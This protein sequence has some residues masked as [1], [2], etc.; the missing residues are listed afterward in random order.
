MAQSGNTMASQE[1]SILPEPLDPEAL[2]RRYRALRS[3]G[4]RA[5]FVRAIEARYRQEPH[6]L[7]L[8]A[9]HVRLA[10]DRRTAGEQAVAWRWALPLALLNGFLFWILTDDRLGV[11]LPGDRFA[12]MPLLFPYWMPVTAALLLLFLAGAGERRWR[13]AA[14][15]VAALAA[16]SLYVYL[17]YTRMSIRMVAQQYVNLAV[18]HLPLLA[19]AAIGFYTLAG[20]DAPRQRFALLQKMLETL[21]V[22]GMFVL[23]AGVF[24][25]ITGGLFSI[26]QVD[27]PDWLIRLALAG[28]VGL[29]PILA[30]ALVYDPTR[31]PADQT[32]AEGVSKTVRRLLR[33]MVPLSV[34]VLTVY[35]ALIPFY[36]REPL[37]NRN[38]LIVY[39]SMLFAVMVLMLG[40][41]PVDEEGEP[42]PWL[43]WGMMV[44]ALLAVLV[45]LYALY[46][47]LYRTWHG[48]LT[49]H[50]VAFIGWDVLNLALLCWLLLTL[51]RRCRETEWAGHVQK[52]FAR[53]AV[54]YPI[55][56]LV[57]LL[58]LPWWFGRGLDPTYSHLPPR[59]QEAIYGQGYPILLKC[60]GSPH[61]YLL[62]RGK[63]RWIKDIP[64]FEAQGFRWSDVREVP[65][66]D[67]RRIPDGPPIPPT[68]GTPPVPYGPYET[69]VPP[70]P[71]DSRLP[72]RLFLDASK[73]TLPIAAIPRW[74]P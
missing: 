6:N 67:L 55:W 25:S 18:I 45:G 24:M 39:T 5:A 51:W 40:I 21:F 46:A 10:W 58:A 4:E 60:Y 7:L 69:P 64:T 57:V 22:A 65:C 72:G 11:R 33:I 53:A 59:V 13:R 17:A 34:V 52:V 2:E 29:I 70:P 32:F 27:F 15:G 41:T 38:A 74:Y 47:I 54:V 12:Y 63:K 26:L 61:V 9:W 31:A 50:R 49:P 28:G 1:T 16:V 20:R 66:A 23:V 37:H 62:E 73:A 35:A 43:R 68:A 19:L 14:G 56:A 44:L 71:G 42:L 48:V 30:T 8:A 3:E 36:A